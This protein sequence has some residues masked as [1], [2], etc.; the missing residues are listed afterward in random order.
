MMTV[1]SSECAVLPLVLKRKWYDMIASGEKREEYRERKPY[2]EKRILRWLYDPRPC[3]I[4]AFSCGYNKP[5]MWFI[6]STSWNTYIGAERPD[7]G[8]PRE[9]HFKIYLIERV[10]LVDDGRITP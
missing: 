5:G 10:Q 7:L 4:V 9:E 1:K 3:H 2:W 6:A 8:E